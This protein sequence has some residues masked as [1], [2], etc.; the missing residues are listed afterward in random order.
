MK[1]LYF[2]IGLFSML[3]SSAMAQVAVNT[4]GSLPDNSAMLDVK[5]TS[6]GFLPPRMTTVQ[7]NAI[8]SPA[9]GLLVF[10]I[11]LN[12]LF[13]FNGLIWK[14]FNE[15]YMETDPVFTAHPASGITAGN[16]G[17]WNTAYGWGNHAA[18]GYLTSFTEVDPIFGASAAAGI[19]GSSLTNWN[20]AYTRRINTATGT[21]PLTL[22][23]ANNDLTG[24]IAMANSVTSGYLNVSDWN[25]FNNK[26]SSQW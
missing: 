26:I 21:W 12:S 8:V 3:A 19:T 15:P 14:Q 23:I 5:S 24:S 6:K 13:W 16:I 2:L 22:L 4:D 1:K 10:D 17:N 25:T 20:L 11:T 9:K 18:A 7:R